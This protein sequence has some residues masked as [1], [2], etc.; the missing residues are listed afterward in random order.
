VKSEKRK[1]TSYPPTVHVAN[2]QALQISL[3]FLPS[4]ITEIKNTRSAVHKVVA[5]TFMWRHVS[6]KEQSPRLTSVW[7]MMIRRKCTFSQAKKDCRLRR[8]SSFVRNSQY[9]FS[10][11]PPFDLNC[12]GEA[13]LYF[14]KNSMGSGKCNLLQR[15]T[16]SLRQQSSLVMNSQYSVRA[17]PRSI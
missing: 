17:E 14:D 4:P 13:G 12:K 16:V 9:S 2:C 10:A 3:L 11:E 15:R 5:S 7:G 8:Q 1:R 6:R